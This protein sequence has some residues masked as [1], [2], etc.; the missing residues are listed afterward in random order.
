MHEPRDSE[1]QRSSPRS[2]IFLSAILRAGSQQS[3]VRIRN[4][5]LTGAMIDTPLTPPQGTDVLLVRASLIVRGTVAWSSGKQCG[6]R[7][8]SEVAVKDWMAA[9]ER[10]DQAR[11]DEAV[12]A[13]KSGSA[14]SPE[15]RR[16]ATRGSQ[17]D[18]RSALNEVLS[19]LQELE[20]DL[21]SSSETVSRHAAK[22]QNL[23]LAMQLL[24]TLQ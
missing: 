1:Q 9:P 21:S 3:P 20:D 10:L 16:L 6:L 22:L 17:P 4:M 11:V 13:I 5:S 8:S 7:F 23:D 24:R 15:A 12:R 19:L 18:S 14:L 2:S